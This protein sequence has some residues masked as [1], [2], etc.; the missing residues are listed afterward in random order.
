LVKNTY[1]FYKINIKG[2][3]IT[4]LSLAQALMKNEENSKGLLEKKKINITLIDQPNSLLK[5]N[6]IYRANRIPDPNIISLTPATIR[7]LDSIGLWE[8]LDKQIIKLVKGIQIWET[9]GSSYISLDIND[10]GNLKNNSII[11]FFK[12]YDILNKNEILNLD[13]INNIPEDYICSLT[14]INHIIV[15][16]QEMLKNKIN[17]IHYPILSENI[18][19]ENTEDFS[20]LT[21]NSSEAKYFSKN[22]SPNKTSQ[23][24]ITYR[25]KLLIA[26]DGRNSAIRSKLNIG[27]NGYQNNE[28]GLI[29]TLRGNHCLDTV[30]QRYVHNGV[31]VLL[32]LY[33]NLYSMISSMPEE[34]NNELKNIDNIKFIEFVNNLLH[35]PSEKDFVLS[36]KKF[37][38]KDSDLNGNISNIKNNSKYIPPPIIEEIVTERFNFNIE[39]KIANKQRINNVVL[40]GEAAHFIYPM[41]GQGMNL[42]IMDSAFLAD[43]IIKVLNNGGEINDK[44]AL[45]NF[46]YRSQLNTRIIIATM[47][48]LRTIY[49]PTN[50]LFSAIR[51]IGMTV[52]NSSDVIRG[53]FILSSSGIPAHPNKF[54]WEK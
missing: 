15:H 20:Y 29:C 18:E 8:R 24:K 48:S 35:N 13:I 7:F 36:L 44:F 41:T 19:I 42:S 45:D 4:G 3:G 46:T 53:L 47:E 14:E 1:V 49:G 50:T 12:K 21:L 32:P 26:N 17:I 16:L 23:K 11:N 5:E 9:K 43:E 40:I 37:M 10:F 27:T 52:S 51:N 33:D 22:S 25:T 31:F 39:C 6:Y 54:S 2:G 34:N 28:S 38:K 30:F